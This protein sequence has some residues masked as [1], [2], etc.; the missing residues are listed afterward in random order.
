V[1]AVELLTDPSTLAYSWAS[2]LWQV[3]AKRAEALY[4]SHN[5]ERGAIMHWIVGVLVVTVAALVALVVFLCVVISRFGR[6]W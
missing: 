2:G 3:F 4:K 1:Q 6:R 5:S